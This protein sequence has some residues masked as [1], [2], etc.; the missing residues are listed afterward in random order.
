MADGFSGNN[1][2]VRV[3]ID[4]PRNQGRDFSDV[5]TVSDCTAR[6]SESEHDSFASAGLTALLLEHFGESLTISPRNKFGLPD[7][8]SMRWPI[9][10]RFVSLDVP[11]QVISVHGSLEHFKGFDLL[12][13]SRHLHRF[14]REF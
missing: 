1:S 10:V 7:V 11:S 3:H 14:A 12:I 8:R 13:G 5:E 2:F 6:L 4:I 9:R